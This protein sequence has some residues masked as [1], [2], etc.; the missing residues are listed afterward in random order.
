[1]SFYRP[2]FFP[3]T[4]IEK[5]IDDGQI[6]TESKK[7]IDRER[8][9]QA[10]TFQQ[11]IS[12]DVVS[13]ILEPGQRER[14]PLNEIFNLPSGVQPRPDTR[15][16]YGKVDVDAWLVTPDGKPLER[17]YDGRLAAEITSHT[18]RVRVHPGLALNHTRFYLGDLADCKVPV[19]LLA[20]AGKPYRYTEDDGMRLRLGLYSKNG[21]VVGHVTK[22]TDKVLDLAGGNPIGD[23]FHDIG[24]CESVLASDRLY[25]F[26]TADELDFS[27]SVEPFICEMPRPHPTKSYPINRASFIEYGSWPSVKAL[28]MRPPAGTLLQK[29]EEVCNIYAYSLLGTPDRSYHPSNGNLN[30]TQ[31]SSGIMVV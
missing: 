2:G 9:V 22:E 7:Q 15:S 6:L 1:M 30:N 13:F 23:F 27:D 14:V 19:R 24:S 11:T 31:L 3:D 18:H 8:D 10:T 21:G 4:M 17:G 16:T 25:L 28:E 26:W 5:M 12:N 29:G 20:R